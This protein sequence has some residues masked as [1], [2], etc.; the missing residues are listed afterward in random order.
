MTGIRYDSEQT[1]TSRTYTNTSSICPKI[2]KNR[3]HMSAFSD[4]ALKARV[5]SIAGEQSD[6]FGLIGILLAC[7]V[8]VA[9]TLKSCNA[10]DGFRR[11]WSGDGESQS[12]GQQGRNIAYSI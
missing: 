3:H 2:V 1:K 5:E 6:Q 9:D 12:E 7:A 8:V 4:R 11:A 10:T